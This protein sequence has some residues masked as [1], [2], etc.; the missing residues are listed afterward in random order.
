MNI[1]RTQHSLKMF[2]EFSLFLSTE[3]FNKYSSYEQLPFILQKHAFKLVLRPL[4]SS[5]NVAGILLSEMIAE[6]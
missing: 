5:N 2:E 4:I 1:N 3:A 6:Y